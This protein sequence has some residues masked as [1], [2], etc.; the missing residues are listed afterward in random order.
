M[1]V[2]EIWLMD[3][4]SVG[5]GMV[6]AKTG[7]MVNEIWLMDFGS[8]HPAEPAGYRPALVLG[9]PPGWVATPNVF[10]VP[11]TTTCRNYP[12]YVEVEPS[13]ENGL[14]EVSYLQCEQ[15]RS[16]NQNRYVA[17]LGLLS[18]SDRIRVGKILDRIRR[19]L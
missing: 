19:I 2:N 18:A 9:L 14:E 12:S 15:I 16:V 11:F 8:G 1:P 4:G 10:V 5:L 7:G 3:F 17:T 13:E 6:A